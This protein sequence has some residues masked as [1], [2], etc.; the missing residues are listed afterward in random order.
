M[1]LSG[2]FS[3]E[4]PDQATN[5]ISS[6][7]VT[8]TKESGSRKS[9]RKEDIELQTLQAIEIPHSMFTKRQKLFICLLASFA[10]MFSTLCSYIYYPALVPIARDLSVSVSLIN[11]T[12]TS[13]L[14]IAAVVPAFMGVMADQSGRRPVYI[15]MFVL[16]IAANIGI[17]LQK[18]FGALLALRM[19][20]SAGS[21]G[22]LKRE[23]G[24]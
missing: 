6:A 23:Q 19:L 24:R 20:Q 4:N 16:F 22:M 21:S 5:E 18:S 7:S 14:I 11:L 10:G 13:Y 17:A 3:T 9:E 12:I 2:A 8:I 1:S 15:L